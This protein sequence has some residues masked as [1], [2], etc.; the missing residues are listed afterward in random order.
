MQTKEK[1]LSFFNLC[2]SAGNVVICT[3]MRPDGDA[4]GSSGAVFHYLKALG[5]KNVT[6]VLP[7]PAAQ[8]IAFIHDG[9]DSVNALEQPAEAKRLV[10]E[11]DLIVCTDFNTPSRA[12]V[13]EQPIRE[14]T[15]AKVLFDHHLDPEQECFDLVFSTTETS[16]CCE[17]LY[18]ILPNPGLAASTCLMAGMTTDTN[19]FANS[20]Y[21]STL[22]MASALI[23]AGVDRDS[24]VQ[25]L[26][27]RYR[28]NRVQ[29]I[30]WFLSNKLK[31]R[32]NGLASII[33]SLKEWHDFGLED[34]EL[35][36]MVNVPLFIN[37][38]NT[39][40]YLR[41]DRTEP[42]FHVS[43]RSKKGWSACRLAKGSFHGGGHENASGG[44]LRWP[45]D[46]ASPEQAE[47]YLDALNP[48]ESK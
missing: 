12:G 29:A 37:E 2:S 22:R 45:Q 15:A 19:N 4:L 23:E 11:A 9:V 35:E 28:P 24:L 40:I 39:V 47:A 16:S 38:V 33:V 44:R 31:L 25:K 17:V 43:I 5:V 34:G 32:P 8:T 48:I 20:V 36:G 1:L 14:S 10:A 41:Q 18:D 6:V 7:D 46:I 42:H 27:F 30:A 13:L 21:P 3:H 26:Y